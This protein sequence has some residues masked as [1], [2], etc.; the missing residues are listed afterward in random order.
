M[1]WPRLVGVPAS[2]LRGC[3]SLSTLSL[4]GNP[5]TIEHLREADGWA[6]FD[7]RRRAKHDKQL[8]MRVMQPSAGFDEGADHTEWQSW[9]TAAG[10]K[11]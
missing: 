11:P 7:A 1:C 6:E 9:S 4:H 10:S 8:S 5:L 3:S 2:I